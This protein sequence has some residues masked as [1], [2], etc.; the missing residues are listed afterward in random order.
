MEG[1]FDHEALT[2]DDVLLVPG[3]SAVLPHEVDTGTLFSRRIPLNIPIVSAA[4]DTVTDANLAIAIAREG[5]LGILHR[6]LAP[7]AQ[8]AEVDLV[9]RSESGMIRDPITLPPERPISEALALMAK[10][11]ISGIPITREGRLVG[12]LTNRDLRFVERTDIP[13]EDVMTKERIVTA[14][15]GTTLEEAKAILHKNRI[16]KLPVVDREFRLKG[17]I[18]VKDIKK[19]MDHPMAS[20][21]AQGR[22]RVGAALGVGKDLEERVERLVR[23]A[24]DALVIDTAH[25][26][27]ENVRQAVKRAR[28]MAPDTDIVAGNVG[29]REGAEFLIA[30]GV[31]AVKVGIGPGASCTTRVVAGVGV[32]QVTAILECAQAT[33]RARIPLIADGGIKYSGDVVKALAAGAQSVMIGS[34]FAGTEESPGEVVL[35]EG[36]SYKVYRGMGSLA[37][38]REGSRDRYG[39]Q[40]V[41]ESKLVPEGIEGRVPYRGRLADTIFQMVGGLRSGMGYLGARNLGEFQ[42]NARFV[43]ITQAGLAE[44]HPHDVIITKEAPNYGR[45]GGA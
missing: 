5:G 45:R 44:S 34:L 37:A 22:L 11:R 9:K 17:L 20:K 25:G 7:E 15:E 41:E 19:K 36:R 30:E 12:V 42:R 33:A 43:R 28:R 32:P 13:I 10:Y 3:H 1:R 14:A 27:T 26:H 38:M 21:D 2:F 16:E 6:N 4:M 8:A 40:D 23:A 29:T 24:A 31:D 39:Q 18:T 35:Y